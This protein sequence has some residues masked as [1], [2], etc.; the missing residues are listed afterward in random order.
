MIRTFSDGHP[1]DAVRHDNVRINN[2]EVWRYVL[3]FTHQP[4]E[5]LPIIVGDVI[6]NVRSALDHMAVAMVPNDRRRK[7]GF[8]IF[9][10]CP[11]DA[12]GNVFD[13]EQGRAWTKFTTG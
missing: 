5:N 3:R 1:Y 2:Q 7:A 12:D 4:D 11:Y 10:T 9:S 13:T 8:P 6:H